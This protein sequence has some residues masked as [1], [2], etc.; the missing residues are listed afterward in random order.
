MKTIK[1][2]RRKT[3]GFKKSFSYKSFSGKVKTWKR[4]FGLTESILRNRHRIGKFVY[5]IMY[6]VVNRGAE[7]T[8]YKKK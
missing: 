6:L 5:G 3:A 4:M 8:I 7:K 1:K 2:S